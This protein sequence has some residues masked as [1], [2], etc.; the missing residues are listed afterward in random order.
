MKFQYASD[1]FPPAPVMQVRFAVPD[2]A[3]R[4][5]PIPALVDSGCV[6]RRRIW[7]KGWRGPR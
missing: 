2:E 6:Y 3:L 7:G 4:L 1:Y 5:G